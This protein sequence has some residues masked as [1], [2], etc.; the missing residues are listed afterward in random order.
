MKSHNIILYGPPG[1]GK[2]YR[3]SARAV[4]LIEERSPSE[5][6]Q[7]YP[8]T[9]RSLLQNQIEQYRQEGRFAF[10]VFH[11]SFSYEDFVEGIR[12]HSNERKELL[13]DVEDGIFKQMCVRAAHALYLSQ[14][15]N[16]LSTDVPSRHN[17]DALFFEF[18]DYL[19]RSLADDTQETVFESKTG[20]PF[21]LVDINKNS[22]LFLRTGKSKRAYPITKGNLAKL[23][24]TFDA[25]E[26]IKSLRRDM[27]SSIQRV[28][29][30]AWAVFHRLKRYEAT[31]NQT[32][33]YLLG[34]KGGHDPAHYLAMKR[35]VARLDYTSL[36]PEDYSAAG[37]F[38]LVIDEINRGN[39]AA[40]FGELIALLEDDKRAG[41]P[42]ALQ[43]ILPYSREIFSVPPNLL[44]LG[45]MNT[46]DRSVEALDTALRR[47]F[48]FEAVNPDPDLLYTVEIVLRPA[49]EPTS[50]AELNLAAEAKMTYQTTR[51]TGTTRYTVDLKKLLQV[52]NRRLMVL[53]DADHQLGHGYLLSIR[54]AENPLEALRDTFYYK[55]I[56]LLQEYF[57][58]ETAKIT[59]I[60][61]RDFFISTDVGSGSENPFAPSDGDEEWLAEL[62]Q[63]RNYQIRPLSDQ[64]FINAVI[65]IYEPS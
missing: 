31:R 17:F 61:G 34:G 60:I 58:G 48:S 28:S 36:R 12:P 43:T 35:D 10:V 33:Q 39:V 37:N 62:S 23:Y 46:A 56:P 9:D 44:L 42:E 16:A 45:T 32:Y 64:A 51:T 21:Y 26:D 30:V 24:R 25:A 19:K 22:T 55:I 50:K 38:V 15:K 11:P 7:A 14:Q 3:T 18:I 8:E 57:F 63:Q 27:P 5:F 52:I 13:Y 41:Q 49:E 59:P 29:S 1:T 4:Q 6:L 54:S 40:I 65:K 20:K 2:T 47:R 53:L